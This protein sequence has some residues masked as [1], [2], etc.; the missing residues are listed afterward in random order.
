MITAYRN[1]EARVVEVARTLDP[2]AERAVVPSCPA[3]QVHD[4]LA[5]MVGIPAALAAGHYPA[6]DLDAW[7]AS[8]VAERRDRPTAELIEEWSQCDAGVEPI[9]GT[10]GLLLVD[11]VVHEGDLRGAL[12]RSGARDADEVTFVLPL[13]LRSLAPSLLAAHLGAITVEADGESWRTHDA[14]AGWT[15]LVDPWEATRLLESRRT[16]SEL[17]AAPARGDA[18]PYVAVLDAHLPLPPRSLDEV[19]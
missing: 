6:G 13:I 15:L 9:L 8:L 7:L 1:T 12:G 5:H 16:A 17:L 11:L 19:G 18:T 14:E 10:E 3:W 4:L 2:E